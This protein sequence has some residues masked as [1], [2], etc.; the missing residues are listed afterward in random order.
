MKITKAKL[1]QIIKEELTKAQAKRKKEIKGELSSLEG[2][3]KDIEH[4]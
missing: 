4:T 2:E 3:L 1:K